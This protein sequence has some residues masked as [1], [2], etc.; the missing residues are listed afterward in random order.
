MAAPL[1][2]LNTIL[3][4]A[5]ESGRSEREIS[6]GRHRPARGLVVDQDRSGSVRG[7]CPSALRG[8]R[9][10]VLHRTAARKGQIHAPARG[11]T[12]K[13]RSEIGG[14]RPAAAV[15]RGIAGRHQGRPGVS[16]EHFAGAK[17]GRRIGRGLGPATGSAGHPARG[18]SADR[19]GPGPSWRAAGRRSFK[20]RGLSARLAGPARI[21]NPAGAPCSAWRGDPW[22]PTVPDGSLVL[23]DCT[24]RGLCN[25]RVFR[26]T[27][28]RRSL[29]ETRRQR[30]GRRLAALERPSRLAGRTV[31]RKTPRSS[32]RSDGW[33]RCSLDRHRDIVGG[34]REH[35]PSR[36]GA[37]AA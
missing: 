13:R 33:R 30:C 11:A 4:A 18:N 35:G 29:G 20:P 7:T 17:A 34:G 1:P 10:R 12:A 3:D 19:D 9:A 26:G 16:A 2:Y 27:H 24:R 28:R 36:P 5:R 14:R 8:P 25:G 31:A 21:R 6:R 37:G 22:K 15:G 32:V 23:I